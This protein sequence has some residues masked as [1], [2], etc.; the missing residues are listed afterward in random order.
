MSQE[1][2]C[3]IEVKL[4]N[5][6]LETF[7]AALNKNQHSPSIS[8]LYVILKCLKIKGMTDGWRGRYTCI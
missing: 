5:V 1:Q 2:N 3:E 8:I 6:H 7:L 4:E